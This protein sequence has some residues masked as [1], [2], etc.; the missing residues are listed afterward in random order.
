MKKTLALFLVSFLSLFLELALVRWI[1]AEVRIFAYCKNLVL[2]SAFLGLGWGCFR[3]DRP[4]RLWVS[5]AL[6]AVLAALL[7]STHPFVTASGPRAVTG[8]LGGFGEFQIFSA[9]VRSHG[10]DTARNLLFGIGWTAA[11][12]FGIAAILYPYGQWIGRMF[13]GFPSRLSAYTVNLVGALA[14]ILGFSLACRVDT[15]PVHWFGLSLVLALPWMGTRRAWGVG[16]ASIAALVFVLGRPEDGADERWSPYQKLNVDASAGVVGVN[17]TGYQRVQPVPSF[18]GP[19]KV[20]RFTMP[21]LTGRGVP[22]RVLVVGAGIGNDVAI[23]LAA[24]VRRVVA[25]EIDPVIQDLGTWMHPARPYDSDRVEVV[26]EDARRYLRTAPERFDAI[27]FSHLD[28]HTLLGGYTNVRLD[29]YIYT[30]ESFRSAK[31]LLTERGFVY[32]SFWAERDWIVERFHG[33][34]EEAF[35]HPPLSLVRTAPSPAG[36]VLLSQFLIGRE[37]LDAGFLDRRH[38]GWDAYRI[39]ESAA[40]DTPRSTDDWPFLY[41]HRRSVPF[42]V[43]AL[44]A[45]LLAASGLLLAG[46]LRGGAGIDWHFFLL[47]AAFL[48]LEFH[49]LSRLALLFGTTW[50]VNTWVI[51]AILVTIVLANAFVLAFRPVRRGP[52]Y[53][54]LVLSLAG[55]WLFPIG[56]ASGAG[57]AALA[58]AV[59]TLPIF[60]AGTIFALSFACT[61]EPARVL[62]SNMLGSIAGGLLESLSF[63]TGL[64]SLLVACLALYLL[65]ALA[66]RRRT[67]P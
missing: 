31:D 11:I 32:V 30:V 7:A 3:A 46:S 61:T 9:Q 26:I 38:P 55:A 1:G 51:A 8:A 52:F 14:G 63:V 17:N 15:A 36:P 66:L 18:D 49:N 42:L 53:V 40:G 44:S 56:R 45:V 25:V 12:F 54:L 35:G 37:P 59:Y 21:Y 58:L 27:V 33:N 50:W 62:G 60:A 10:W 29:N 47:G 64:S 20:D 5:H 6:V 19:T 48:L 67:V 22:D 28:S 16:L 65:S 24:G 13:E 57:G 43:A 39:G 34:L 41:V 4:A 2:L 23:A